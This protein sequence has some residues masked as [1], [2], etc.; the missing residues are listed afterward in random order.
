MGLL[1]LLS[2]LL[3]CLAT[4]TS[5][6]HGGS[7]AAARDAGAAGPRAQAAAS[8]SGAAPPSVAAGRRHSCRERCLRARCG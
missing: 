8:G 2:A 5:H 6:A 4:D 3:A 1:A 7:V